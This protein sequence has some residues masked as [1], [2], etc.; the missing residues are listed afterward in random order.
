MY[1][2]RLRSVVVRF[3]QTFI[4]EPGW[5]IKK[6]GSSTYHLR[7]TGWEK[8]LF[9]KFYT[10]GSKIS[11]V[12][13]EFGQ[14]G[15]EE[16]AMG[17]RLKLSYFGSATASKEREKRN[18]EKWKGVV[19]KKGV[20]EDF[21]FAGQEVERPESAWTEAEKALYRKLLK[22]GSFD[23]LVVPFQVQGYAVDRIGRFL[24]TRYLARRVEAAGLKVPGP[25]LVARALGERMR[26][27]NDDDIYSLA[28]ELGVKTVIRGYAGHNLDE[29]LGVTLLVD[30]RKK[31]RGWA[32]SRGNPERFQWNDVQFSD[33]RPPSEAF[34]GI[35]DDVMSKLPFDETKKSREVLYDRVKAELPDTVME[36][37]TGEGGSPVVDAYSLQLIG[38][39]FPRDDTRRPDD[40]IA[41]EHF[42]ERSLVAL[43]EVSPS[44]PDYA[45]LKARAFFYLHRRP[46]A[47]AA[48]GEPGTVEEKALAALLDGNLYEL[49]ALVDKISSPLTR[50]MM[51]IDLVDL[52][53]SYKREPFEEEYYADII[54]EFPDWEVAVKRR[55][56]G[57]D[58]WFHQSNLVVK[59]ELD[60]VFP[61][62][63]YT[64]ESIARNSAVLGEN[65]F[66]GE[67]VEFSVYTHRRRLFE[68]EG[69]RFC[70]APGQ[71][72]P[73]EA[74]YLDLLAAAGDAN[75]LHNINRLLFLQ[76]LPDA[77]METLN[78][79]DILYRGHPEMESLKI[80]ALSE[81]SKNRRQ[82]TVR[83][84]L[85]KERKKRW[86]DICDWSQGQD[87]IALAG[88]SSSELFYE[89]D[90]PRHW[91]SGYV[92]W[93]KA[94][95]RKLDEKLMAEPDAGSLRESDKYEIMNRKLALWYSHDDFTAFK[96]YYNEFLDH[97]MYKAAA[98]LLEDNRH[99][100]IG[101]P[102]RLNYFAGIKEKGGYIEAARRLYED[103]IA[104]D[105]EKWLPYFWLARTYIKEGDF[106]KANEVFL[107]YPL[108]RGGKASRVGLSNR[109][110]NAGFEL[111]Y[112]GAIEE[113]VPLFKL[114]EGYGTG[115]G[116]EMMSQLSLSLIKED[117]MEAVY[118][119]LRR[120]KRYKTSGGYANYMMLLHLTGYSEEAW[121]L[122][123]DIFEAKKKDKNIISAAAVLHRIGGKS[124]GE[125]REWLKED[126]FSGLDPAYTSQYLLG[127][128]LPD[129]PPNPGLAD[130]IEGL[131]GRKAAAAADPG[132]RKFKQH[133]AWFAN[134]YYLLKVKRFD[135]AY[136][137]F[138]TNF[139]RFK[140]K[141]YKSYR[142]AFPYIAWSG[143]KA[144]ESTE[145]GKHL[146][147]YKKEYGEDFYFHLSKALMA[148]G[149]GRHTEALHRLE[150]ARNNVHI[151]D[152]RNLTTWYELV[153]SAEWLYEDSGREE[154][155]D[156]ALEWAKL[157][158]R[159]F[160]WY[161]W[162]YA[163]E[164]KYTDS[165]YD[166][167][168]AL[169]I[170]LY[171]DRHSERISGFSEEER[172]E[173][174]EWL[175]KNNPFKV[176]KRQGDV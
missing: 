110:Y 32:G 62:E 161:A 86:H 55:F 28:Y 40:P 68:K 170:T 109:A 47:L 35:L 10:D 148:G 124:D 31:G 25:T 171:L 102:G 163:V 21:G 3:G 150:L 54:K 51:M 72:R 4:S 139:H 152:K 132:T 94:L 174:L 154:Y 12:K 164:A 117:Y 97:K 34:R 18:T 42:F 20:T 83:E 59:K 113:A 137:S 69:K 128:H 41:S 57:K 58:D 175:E 136:K 127:S 33:E 166:R 70:C 107:A 39:L 158:R 129:R 119:S 172:E 156:L 67:D 115:S 145:V 92:S 153:E 80:S 6:F 159:I 17:A 151:E 29:K 133:R 123:D 91:Y 90:Y 56:E 160:P 141:T 173:A 104:H 45:F 147:D 130:F 13:G 71:V 106:K 79:Y 155:R 96:K 16:L 23:V 101:N 108:F 77:A 63:G 60:R 26:S 44:S 81:I 149:K 146:G 48:L 168:R 61:V 87:R 142:Y 78:R 162:A 53:V 5:E 111:L 7:L 105:P 52:N 169:A 84:N 2:P 1:D 103:A 121:S 165:D 176:R 27:F 112:V 14:G 95:D 65:P 8:G 131:K 100:F 114:S 74:D 75:L 122:F 19:D 120:A 143:A 88:C 15:G 89:N 38:T 49:E 144:G 126:R 36:T 118:H 30:K 66:G 24:M 82:G 76:G 116:R 134:G 157:Y 73:V 98:E 140:K 135:D 93:R 9:W 125:I 138:K 22:N 37:F 43:G 46:A 50:L 85:L 167:L 11:R 64:A 99:R